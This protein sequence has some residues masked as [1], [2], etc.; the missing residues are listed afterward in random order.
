MVA[1]VPTSW[2][3]EDAMCFPDYALTL[4]DV[5]S[6]FGGY[7]MMMSPMFGEDAEEDVAVYFA[8]DEESVDEENN[9]W[10]SMIANIDEN[11]WHFDDADI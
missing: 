10:D 8:D 6:Y 7:D 11:D 3:S 2:R 1:M 9:S 4:N 5:A